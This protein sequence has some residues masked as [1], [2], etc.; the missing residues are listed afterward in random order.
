MTIHANRGVIRVS[1]NATVMGIRIL[2]V[3]VRRIP[4]V[5]G[6]DTGKDRV[7]GRIDMAI[8]T[9]RTIVGNSEGGMVENRAQPGC[10]RPR[11]VTGDAG[12][13][14]GSG[15]VIRHVCSIVLC[16]GVVRLMATVTVRGWIARCIVAA[17]V[18]V[19]ARIDHRS[20]R[21]RHCC[22]RRQH[23]RTLKRETSRSVVELSIGPKN[24]VVAGRT[25]G[26]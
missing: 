9:R 11:C 25:H 26:S 5:T 14:I 21:T 7:V 15:H 22:T 4:G 24:S 20:D 16:R 12:C 13:R 17:D 23:M 8:G 18:A 2:L 19:G 1:A 10:G 6:I 3:R